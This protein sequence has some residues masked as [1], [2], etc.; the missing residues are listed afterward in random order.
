MNKTLLNN[1]IH[2]NSNESITMFKL[3]TYEYKLKYY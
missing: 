1:N 3:S 2:L